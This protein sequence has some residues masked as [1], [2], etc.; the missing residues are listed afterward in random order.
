MNQDEKGC[1]VTFGLTAK[2]MEAIKTPT[3]AQ[4]IVPTSRRYTVYTIIA[5]ESAFIISAIDVASY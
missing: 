3:L 1:K 4:M 5:H 2:N